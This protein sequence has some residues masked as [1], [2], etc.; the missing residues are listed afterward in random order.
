MDSVRTAGTP[1][2]TLYLEGTVD[3]TSLFHL[4]TGIICYLSLGV[5]FFF[6]LTI[7]QASQM[8][9]MV[10][11]LISSLYGLASDRILECVY[12]PLLMD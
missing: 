10:I 5:V 8:E 4:L 11:W 12:N 3:S 2:E 1:G 6:F 7:C 9:G